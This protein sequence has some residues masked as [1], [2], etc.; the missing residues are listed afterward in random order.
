MI[1]ET[2]T[3]LACGVFAGAALYVT[4]VEQ[5]ARLSCGT[6]AAIAEWKPSYRRG[7]LMQGSLAI[8]GSLLAFLSWWTGKN[9]AWLL[10]G[11]LLFAVVPFTLIVI[12]PVN[13]E[14]ESASLD[15]S[16]PKA[17]GLLRRWG[18]LHA[19]RGGLSLIAFQ[20]FLFALQRK[21]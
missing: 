2:L 6:A 17:E 21:Y 20:I 15:L 4:L 3:T 10:G 18:A 14:L 1:L 12:F 19:V 7:T 8:A 5:P 9:S 11:V 13:R 16:S